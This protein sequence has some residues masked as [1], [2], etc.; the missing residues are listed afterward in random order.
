MTAMAES[1]RVGAG[2]LRGLRVLEFAGIGPAPFACMVLSDMGADVVRIE[3]PDAE[4]ADP[5]TATSRGRTTA[6]L[7][8]KRDVDRDAARDLAA[9]ADVLV[10]G[11]R[12]GVMERLGLG[13]QDLQAINPR[14]I[15]ARMTGWGQHGPLAQAA[16]HDINYIAISGA[17]D[18]I[19][20]AD[21][22][23]VVPLNLVG[24]YG[25]GAM[26]LVSGV[27]A[28]LFERQR[29]G[30]GQVLDVAI[31][32]ATLLLMAPFF[33][34]AARGQWRQGRAGNLLDGGA[35]HYATYRTSDGGYVAIGALEPKFFRELC[36]RIGLPGHLHEAQADP[37]RWPELREAIQ[38]AVAQRS[39][40]E[41]Q[42]LL[43]STD[44]CVAPVL[45]LGE[46]AAHP[47]HTARGSFVDVAGSPQPA[48]VPRFSRT[49]C[50]DPAAAGAQAEDAASVRR[51]WA[52]AGQARSA[53]GR[54]ADSVRQED[55]TR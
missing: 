20:P 33:S 19:G 5:R 29:S 47:H 48:P 16:G 46:V 45:S 52:Q 10:E 4:A 9:C 7:D 37:R 27:L 44:A 54:A 32:D 31:S 40:A 24:D 22:A 6:R 50:A 26:F 18:A 17:L 3:R 38:A 43:E 28:A 55:D 35:P 36:R 12:P 53:K 30:K 39:R 49:P 8:L 11:F 2:P 23:P 51:R 21:S 15:F 14:L 13:P 42:E 41:W 25:A 34:W 1:D